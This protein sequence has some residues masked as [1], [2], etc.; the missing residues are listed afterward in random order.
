[1]FLKNLRGY[2]GKF[3]WK[4]VRKLKADIC[5]ACVAQKKQ[6]EKV[7]G[8]RIDWEELVST[9]AADEVNRDVVVS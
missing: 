2:P 8:R 9:P 5:P 4:Y 6:G 7:Y 1:M 3:G